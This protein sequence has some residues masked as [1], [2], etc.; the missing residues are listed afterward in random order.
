MTILFFRV[1]NSIMDTNTEKACL[2]FI[3]RSC[4]LQQQAQTEKSK[5]IRNELKRRAR[6]LEKI[7][8]YIMRRHDEA[9]KQEGT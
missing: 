8:E 4:E 6:R 2:R 5:V 3:E 7:A 9:N 1:I